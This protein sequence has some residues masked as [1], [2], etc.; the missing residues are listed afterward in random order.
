MIAKVFFPSSITV[1]PGM[2]FCD[3]E[4]MTNSGLKEAT[5]EHGNHVKIIGRDGFMYSRKKFR[6][7]R[8][9]DEVGEVETNPP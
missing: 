3:P 6:G 9:F 1:E 4:Q 8:L 7:R 2:A 5:M